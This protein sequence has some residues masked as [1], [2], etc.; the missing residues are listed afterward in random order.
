MPD[1]EV[2]MDKFIGY[3]Q[4]TQDPELSYTMELIKQ[5]K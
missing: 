5:G 4:Q 1:K 2:P 3:M